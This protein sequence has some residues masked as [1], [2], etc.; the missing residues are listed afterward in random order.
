[1][2]NY[3]IYEHQAIK[4]HSIKFGHKTYH[5]KELNI[6]TLHASGW[7]ILYKDIKKWLKGKIGREYGLDG[8][9]VDEENTYHGI[10][11]KYRNNDSSISAH[12]IPTFF[13]VLTNRLR[14]H[15]P[16]ST[17]F[18]YISTEKISPS[19]LSSC[20]HGGF[21]HIIQLEFNPDFNLDFNENIPREITTF[22]REHYQL[23][24]Y[25]R[26]MFKSTKTSLDRYKGYGNDLWNWENFSILYLCY[27]S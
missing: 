5:W 18:L 14:I 9:S 6:K 11:V 16:Q 23:R 27:S 21:I 19:L 4:A 22:S 7:A 17:G 15:N 20:N 1:M 26:R 24:Y 2:K 10:Q 13:D 25:Q 8:I 12:D 3:E